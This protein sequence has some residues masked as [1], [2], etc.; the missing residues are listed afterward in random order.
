MVRL[1]IELRKEPQ[2]NRPYLEKLQVHVFTTIEI[3]VVAL[4]VP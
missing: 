1:H 3:I 4:K 2:G